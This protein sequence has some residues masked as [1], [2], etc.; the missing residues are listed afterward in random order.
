MSEQMT[1]ARKA[2]GLV[3]VGPDLVVSALTGPWRAAQGTSLVVSDTTRNQGG[4]AAGASVTRFYLSGNGALDATDVLLGSRAVA[5]L[6][7]GASSLASTSL[8]IPAGTVA[9][10]YYVIART[11]DEGAVVET[12]E[13]NN[14][15]A[16][17]LRVDP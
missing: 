9:G 17:S 8:A 16:L 14:T 10:S 11:D 7:A 1:F 3:R 13:T 15:R 12:V 6:A 4:G 5:A 2:S